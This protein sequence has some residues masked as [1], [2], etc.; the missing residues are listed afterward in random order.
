M[1]CNMGRNWVYV[2]RCWNSES[3]NFDNF[4]TLMSN[5]RW[6]VGET[7]RLKTR[8]SEHLNG[9][10]KCITDT[11]PG[12][13]LCVY[14]VTVNNT[15]SEM[16][17]DL[18]RPSWEPEYHPCGYNETWFKPPYTRYNSSSTIKFNWG[19]FNWRC[20]NDRSKEETGNTNTD[21]ETEITHHFFKIGKDDQLQTKGAGL[22]RKNDLSPVK[23][24]KI[25][26]G[27]TDRPYC[28]CGMPCEIDVDEKYKKI[29]YKCPI[30]KSKWLNKYDI[31]HWLQ[32]SLPGCLFQLDV[33]PATPESK[34]ICII[35]DE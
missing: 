34:A 4:K 7:E 23:L 32:N 24:A 28:H 3:E 12:T 11:P 15:F 33:T 9:T 19:L 6:Y 5:G 29:C 8:I 21:L 25:F 1:N 27:L 26:K 16:M 10:T 20:K 30:K 35:S 14:D 22:C 13:I 17:F 31:E 18:N 2:V